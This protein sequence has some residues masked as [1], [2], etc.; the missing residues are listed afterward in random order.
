MDMKPI[1]RVVVLFD[2]AGCAKAFQSEGDEKMIAVLSDYYAACEEVVAAREG[3]VIKFI[4]DGCLSVF[5]EDHAL[6]AVHATTEM[7][8]RVGVLADRL[9]VAIQL[10]A[11]LH[12]ALVYEMPV[13]GRVDIFGRGVNQ[14]FLL[15]RGAGVR[16]SE[17][18]YRALP[19]S[20]RS[21]W[22][23]YKPPAVYHLDA[24]EGLLEGLGK[25]AVQNLERW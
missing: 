7:Q 14:T 23:K 15:G 17:P 25:S 11:N 19:S 13:Q 2:L 6:A 3:R 21:A 16:I 20:A 8:R 5:A 9:H 4:G 12:L 22:M 10:G 24:S 1:K 18:V